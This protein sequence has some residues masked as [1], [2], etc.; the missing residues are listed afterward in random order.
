PSRA[1]PCRAA[2]QERDRHL[3]AAPQVLTRALAPAGR[4]DRRCDDVLDAVAGAGAAVVAGGPAAV[5]EADL[6]E[7]VAP[8][9]PQEVLVQAGRE[10][11]PG[12]H[13]VLGAVAVAVPVH[14][15]AVGLHGRLPALQAEVLAPLLE[16]PALAP[17]LLDDGPEAAVAAAEEALDDAGARVVPLDL[18]VAA[19]LA[20]HGVAQ[21]A[22]LAAQLGLGVRPEPLDRGE[23]L[24]H[25]PADAD[26]DRPLQAVGLGEVEAALGHLDDAER[27]LVGLGGQP[28]E[29]V[30]LHPPPALAERRADRGV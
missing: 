14:V 7:G 27:V 17:D 18:D 16:G 20:L 1:D 2:R 13:L 3:A 12:E 22:D 28:R 23:G 15:E 6:V 5:L 11:V 10:V 19:P 4:G 29:E 24:R 8:L 9:L 30:E 26:R 25:E 21:Q